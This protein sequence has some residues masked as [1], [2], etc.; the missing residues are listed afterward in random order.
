MSITKNP[1]MYNLVLPFRYKFHK[2][3]TN[4]KELI[5]EPN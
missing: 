3:Y 5:K 2:S 1:K 4:V